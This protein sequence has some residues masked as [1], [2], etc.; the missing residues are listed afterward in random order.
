[1]DWGRVPFAF[2]FLAENRCFGEA[3]PL[4]EGPRGLEVP[5]GRHS[6][7]IRR[8]QSLL[9]SSGLTVLTALNGQE[10]A[11]EAHRG[12]RRT[13]GRRQ[14]WAT[15]PETAIICHK[16]EHERKT[17][18]ASRDRRPIAIQ[19]YAHVEQSMPPRTA[20][21]LRA[22]ERRTDI[23]TAPCPCMNRHIRHPYRSGLIPQSDS[24]WPALRTRIHFIRFDIPQAR[25]TYRTCLFILLTPLQLDA[26]LKKVVDTCNSF[27][28]M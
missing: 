2:R 1:M 19:L 28:N 7:R 16:P 25:W 8:S 15:L 4:E 3:R 20:V 22:V 11:R 23:V 27:V 12:R 21:R 5:C 6:P 13:T 9:Y 17:A 18:S 24:S 26:I 10:R 14:D